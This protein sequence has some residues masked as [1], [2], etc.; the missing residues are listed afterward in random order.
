MMTPIVGKVA[1]RLGMLDRPAAHK[2]HRQP[3]PYLGG[4]ALALGLVTI[5]S[6]AAS[7]SGQL[8]TILFGG[9]VLAVWGFVDD[10]VTVGPGAKLLVEIGA[11]VALWLAG[12]RAQLFGIPGLDLALT[13]LWVVA[14]TNAVNLVDNMDGLSCGVAAIAA[15]AFFTIAAS[16][17]NYLTASFAAALAGANL[18]FLRHN[19]P[20]ASIFL[21]DAGTLMIGFLLAAVGLH[22]DLIGNNGLV[23]S[24]IP[25]LILG[26]PLFD[27][28]LVVGSRL[29]GSRPVHRGGTDH[30]S[31]RLT[32][33]GLSG[34]AV[35]ATHYVAETACCGLALWLLHARG[36]LVLPTVLVVAGVA[37]VVLVVLV[38]GEEAHQVTPSEPEHKGAPGRRQDSEAPM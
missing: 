3:T 12:I 38:L 20:P 37:L 33:A 29:R 7:A 19:Y 1:I 4:L 31:H 26:V 24:A 21:G 9:I 22:L 18:G 14:V 30:S 5:G 11:G 23:R 2:F 34:R 32:H 17:G 6:M 16:R 13:V 25:I 15:A 27:M 28:A 10:W 36:H 35:A 8:L